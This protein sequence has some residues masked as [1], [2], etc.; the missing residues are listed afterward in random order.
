MNWLQIYAISWF[1]IGFL[2]ISLAVL[3]RP[4]F[5][6]IKGERRQLYKLT[7]G[8]FITAVIGGPI[9][10]I[11]FLKA[12]IIFRKNLKISP[13][14]YLFKNRRY[15]M[16]DKRLNRFFILRKTAIEHGILK[17]WTNINYNE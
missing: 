3:L 5:I 1:V 10:F 2:S 16:Q 13:S 12:Y 15:K 8:T 7:L 14:N 9:T 11:I 4:P 17:E 6:K